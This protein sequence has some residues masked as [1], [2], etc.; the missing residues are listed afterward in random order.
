MNIG[1]YCFEILFNDNDANNNDV[2]S[3]VAVVSAARGLTF[4]LL[5]PPFTRNLLFTTLT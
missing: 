3:G 5:A 4:S 2:I 1:L